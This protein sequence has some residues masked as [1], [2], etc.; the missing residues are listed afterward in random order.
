MRKI[1]FLLAF[2]T[3]WILS[4][5]E[6]KIVN[7]DPGGWGGIINLDP[8]GSLDVLLD[9]V[10][11]WIWVSKDNQTGTETGTMIYPYNTIQE[12]LDAAGV[13]QVVVVLAPRDNSAYDEHLEMST[14]SVRLMTLEGQTV[15]VE[16]QS[17]SSKGLDITGDGVIIG[18][19]SGMG[20][21]FTADAGRMIEMAADENDVEISYNTIIVDGGGT[22]GVSV[23]AAGATRLKVKHNLFIV[24]SGLGGFFADKNLDDVDILYNE[25]QGADST[26]S[27]AIQMSG[28][29]DGI[30]S[31]NYIHKGQTIAGGFASGI[32]PHTNTGTPHTSDSLE[33]Y[34]NIVQNCS[35]GIRLGH[36]NGADMK[37]IYVYDN[38]LQHNSRGIFVHNDAQVFPATY[39]IYDNLFS[40]NTNDITNDHATALNRGMN[41]FDADI[42]AL[43]IQFIPQSSSSYSEGLIY[44]DSDDKTLIVYNEEADVALSVGEEL[45]KRVRN[46]S[47]GLIAD[48]TP[49]YIIGAVG[50][51]P[52][53]AKTDADIDT[54]SLFAGL[55]T[56]DIEDNSNGY[57]TTYG[58]VRGLDTDGSP[59]S[60]SWSDGDRIYI[61]TT[62]GELTN[63]RP[64]TAFVVCLGHVDFAHTNQGKLQIHP[65][66]DWATDY[67]IV[68]SLYLDYVATSDV[69][70]LSPTT[71]GGTGALD[72]EDITEVTLDT[73]T[74]E[75]LGINSQIV[76]ENGASISNGETDT[77]FFDETVVKVDGDLLVAGDLHVEGTESKSADMFLNSNGNPTT[78][79]TANSPIGMIYYTDGDRNGFTFDAGGTGAITAYAD[80][81]IAAG[82]TVTVTDNTH[83]LDDGDFIVIR[84]TT[85]YNGVWQI[86]LIDVNSF[87]IVATW[88][89][90]D[91]ASDWEEPSYLQLTSSANET[92]NIEWHASSQKASGASATVMW[93]VYKNTTAILKTIT[94]REIPGTD[95]GSV[96]GGGLIVSVSA[97][98]R[99]FMVI[100]S[101]N[102][103]DITNKFGT[104]ILVQE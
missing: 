43:N 103:N 10:Q 45:F 65:K 89:A 85:N 84:G 4:A 16:L 98:D 20:F 100:Q 18:G 39:D 82:D 25:F 32:F 83:G 93:C 79:E 97:G 46:T 56:H 13:S 99:F 64:S 35:N 5:Q 14:D 60:E 57:I 15:R 2:L 61:S 37:E 86:G 101:D 9:S 41:L 24:S 75:Y 102:T 30:I 81:G 29:L 19:G 77:L 80:F 23:G 34:N 92:F 69:T 91:G 42:E 52:T 3:P 104:L 40:D 74:V 95:I 72:T 17:S 67:R 62:L 54:M 12:G 90:D 6:D 50:Q 51:L 68:D 59:Y 49:V 76:F 47:G 21:T 70:V 28:F 55:A 11:N 96:S 88:V 27:Y 58:I 8:G 73:M 66:I 78:M 33:I 63:V 71:T 94:E 48:G 7:I 22:I 87:Y 53:I 36:S 38:I 44:Y 31:Y 1:I 26:S